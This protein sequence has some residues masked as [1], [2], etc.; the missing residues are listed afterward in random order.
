MEPPTQ[1]QK[2]PGGV[3]DIG[4]VAQSSLVSMTGWRSIEQE[5]HQ[6]N[7]FF[8]FNFKTHYFLKKR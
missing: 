4:G 6:S 2:T 5:L 1:Q 8:L 7:R 3:G